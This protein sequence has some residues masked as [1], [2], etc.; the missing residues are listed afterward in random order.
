MA[1]LVGQKK[2]KNIEV[3]TDGQRLIYSATRDYLVYDQ[4]GTE[5]EG[6]ILLTAGLPSVN[7][8]YNFDGVPLALTCKKKS[9]QQWETNNKY[10]TVSA[11]FDNEPQNNEEGTG[12]NEGESQDPTTWFS[13]VKFDFETYEEVHDGLTNLA[14]RPYNPPVTR[15]KLLP[16]IKFTQ[17]MPSTLSI[18]ELIKDY[19]EIINKERFLNA[20]PNY[21]KLSIA[22]AQFG[23]TNGFPCW[24][25]DFEL[26]Y[27]QI[28]FF[29]SDFLF[30]IDGA[31][32]L[33]DRDDLAD[34]TTG[35]PG[36]FA[37][38]PQMDT[39]DIFKR[40]FT[41]A[42]GNTGDFGKLDTNGEFLINQQDI[43]YTRQHGI[44]PI[45]S[46]NFIRIRQG[47]N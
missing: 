41:D 3:A 47:N 37:Y 2:G 33:V 12:G 23:V 13:I 27:K 11:D 31:K 44:Y 36:W 5:G 40:P 4:S 6:D 28:M 46:F 42:L 20:P 34:G 17:Y 15:T 21:W 24:K 9:A 32:K 10:W 45:K 8:F 35:Y 18:Y 38:I 29:D 14:N 16:V 1:T 7:L 25:V 39:I 30:A 43:G 19:H 22:G 26:R